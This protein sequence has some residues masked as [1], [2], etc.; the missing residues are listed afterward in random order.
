VVV[1]AVFH[2]RWLIHVVLIYVADIPVE[3]RASNADREMI[4]R[5][6]VIQVVARYAFVDA[7]LRHVGWDHDGRE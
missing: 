3:N 4:P 5:L 2:H 1:A 6:D 7:L